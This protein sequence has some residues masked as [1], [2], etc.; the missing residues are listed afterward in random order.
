MQGDT[1]GG[2]PAMPWL[3]GLWRRCR[4]IGYRRAERLI[5][6]VLV[7][8]V[9]ILTVAGA[10]LV[11]GSSDAGLP[12]VDAR[13]RHV[14]AAETAEARALF[15]R[16]APA[17]PGDWLKVRPEP[18]QTFHEYPHQVFNRKTPARPTIY[19]VPLG[20]FTPVQKRVLGEMA[21]YARVF[22]NC[23]VRLVRARPLPPDSYMRDRGQYD[24]GAI[25]DWLHPTRPADAVAYVGVTGRDLF[26]RRLNFVFGLASLG[27]RTG[28]YSLHRYGQTYG[29][30]LRRALKVM[31]H[32]V[33]HIFSL[34]HCV[35]YDCSM[36]GSNSLG[37]S[38]TRPI[39]YC[40]VCHA[41]LQWAVGFNP[42]KRLQ[43]LEAYYRAAGLADDAD[44]M[45]R[46]QA[47]W[48]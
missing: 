47:F 16:M 36:N 27:E 46:R 7:A 31:N 1:I 6:G 23:P 13:K 4:G 45:R 29:V 34:R 48:K 33:G 8:L 40:P 10:T 2:Q 35:F 37:E 24:A 14:Y 41:K 26:S 18:G 20:A 12:A 44:F 43:A 39:H 5:P 3:L 15:Q 38:D 28:V 17:Q 21:R 42:L 22:F 19:I 9:L 11:P 25:L 32:E 30:L